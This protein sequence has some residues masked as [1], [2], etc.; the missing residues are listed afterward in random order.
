VSPHNFVSRWLWKRRIAQTLKEDATWRHFVDGDWVCPYCGKIG[1]R[2]AEGGDLAEAALNHLGEQ[3][4]RFPEPDAEPLPP[5]AL[6]R[7]RDGMVCARRIMKE[8]AWKVIDVDGFWFCPFC[9]TATG[10]NLEDLTKESLRPKAEE[11]GEHIE[12]C[13]AYKMRDGKPLPVTVLRKAVGKV[14][15]DKR[16]CAQV[17]R[18]LATDARWKLKVGGGTWLCPVCEETIP[19]I[20]VSSPL[21]LEFTAP[22]K[23]ARHLLYGCPRFQ[24]GK[25]NVR[26]IEDLRERVET[27]NAER[28][29]E[30]SS[31]EAEVEDLLEEVSALRDRL[32]E[33]QDLAD[34]MQK[35]RDIQM[36]MLPK[37]LPEVGGYQFAVKYAA[38]TQVGGDFYDF[39]N[40]MQG[41][42]GLAVGDVSGHGLNAAL[43][44]SMV[45]KTMAIRG[46]GVESASAVLQ[47]TNADVFPDLNVGTFVTIAYGVLDTESGQ[48]RF[49]R[50]GHTPLLVWNPTRQE[51]MTVVNPGGMAVGMDAGPI[52]ERTLHEE[53]V[54]LQP[55]D[56]LLLY[57]DGLTEAMN[58]ASE[59]YG[60]NR[61]REALGSSNAQTS[62][63]LKDAVIASIEAFTEGRPLDDDLTLLVV[64][65]E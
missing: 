9:G 14:N 8:P 28:V 46:R 53:L 24:G 57:T 47:M 20:D 65:R 32:R 52:F 10:V 54:E 40:V 4:E 1:A 35:A 59:Q 6:Q 39:I 15:R 34:S 63:D 17:R 61:L 2:D 36:G 3:C 23:I 44:M 29:E 19:G 49:S 33:T 50:A 62:E 42:L 43:V 56:F 5:K 58:A 12:H 55:G 45:K 60:L 48:Y 41:K 30:V 26:S 64:K 16:A 31:E 7:I 51:P 18:R 22:M 13:Y 38:S 27:L 37:T 21:L 11:V 25:G